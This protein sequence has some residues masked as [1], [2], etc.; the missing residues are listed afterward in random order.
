[1]S[2]AFDSNEMGGECL[3]TVGEAYLEYEYLEKLR[4]NLNR[5]DLAHEDL[6]EL[7]EGMEGLGMLN[8]I[9]IQA[10]KN[11][12]RIDRKD[13]VRDSLNKLMIKNKKIDL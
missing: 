8:Q 10:K 4:L 2:L 7:I 11:I 5:N 13:A 9:Y 1:M 6:V 3:K 12:K